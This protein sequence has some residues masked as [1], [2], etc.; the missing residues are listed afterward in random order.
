M[1]YYTYMTINN[2]DNTKCYVGITSKDDPR[3][4]GSGV[5]IVKAL[6]EYG[7][8]NFSK[9]YLG[10][11]P[12]IQEAH[13]WEGFYIKLY[14]TE[15]KYGGYNISPKGGTYNGC[16]S[17][18]T[19]KLMKDKA[20]GRGFGHIWNLETIDKRNW[21][22]YLNKSSE[23][24]IKKCPICDKLFTTHIKK[25]TCSYSCANKLSWRNGRKITM[26][27]LYKKRVSKEQV[28]EL[29]NKNLTYNKIAQLLNISNRTVR[30]RLNEN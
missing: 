3:Y 26:P 15:V 19:L 25:T 24:E 4:K 8:C 12:T 13:Y 22:Y 27:K 18:E 7:V 23:I 17:D 21:T 29:R 30:N 2:L 9:V 5:E 16:H 6:R 20:K 28:N 14:K 11:F 1:N 10:I